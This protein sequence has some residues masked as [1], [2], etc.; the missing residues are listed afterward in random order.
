MANQQLF[1]AFI[2]VVFI[3]RNSH[4]S[5]RPDDHDDDDDDG[6]DNNNNNVDY[7]H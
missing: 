4:M 7:Y 2:F 5:N 3:F 6:D 1:W